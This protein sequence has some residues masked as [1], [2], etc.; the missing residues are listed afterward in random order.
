M[1][2]SVKHIIYLFV[3]KICRIRS[4]LKEF[5]DNHKKEDSPQKDKE[6]QA[7]IKLLTR[8]LPESVKAAEFIGKFSQHLIKD[9]TLLSCK[10]IFIK[11]LHLVIN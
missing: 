8:Y 11:L 4:H 7:S 10:L 6:I 3:K 1:Y 9:S 2:L 5:L